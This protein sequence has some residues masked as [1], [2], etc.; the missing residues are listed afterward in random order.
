MVQCTCAGLVTG[1]QPLESFHHP[2]HCAERLAAGKHSC[3]SLLTGSPDK[4]CCVANTQLQLRF[5]SHSQVGTLPPNAACLV[6]KPC[7]P[8]ASS[9]TA[10][11]LY[12]T[13]PLRHVASYSCQQV[14][15]K[16]PNTAPSHSL[17]FKQ[18]QRH[19]NTPCTPFV[20]D[21]HICQIIK[22]TG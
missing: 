15:R 3:D 14:N 10:Y 8:A 13:C 1:P 16:S 11:E 18:Q 12:Y 22:P 7:P 9:P 2:L 19:H 17:Q 4:M 21:Q 6:L 20:M 5:P